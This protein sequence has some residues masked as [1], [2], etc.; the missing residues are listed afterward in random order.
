[1]SIIIPIVIA[2]DNHY[3]MPAGVSLYSML[4]CT[5]AENPQSQNPQ[6]QNDSKK[7]FYK[8]HCLVDNLSLENQCK[9]KETLAPFSAFMSLEFLD[10]STPNLH[11]TPIEP[12]VI[13]K[14]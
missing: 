5:K 6:S 13:D 8:I 12:S 3:A 9:L 11:T 14:I 7:L 2:F 10:I 4:T 1:M